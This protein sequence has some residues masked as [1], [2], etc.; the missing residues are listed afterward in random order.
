VTP[1]LRAAYAE[2]RRRYHTLAHIE[3]CLARLA[4]ISDLS[5]R[6]HALLTAALWWHDAV[7]DPTRGDNEALSAE[8]A[9]RDLPPLGYAPE[10]VVEIERLILLTKGHQVPADDPLG[11]LMVSI[12]LSILGADPEIYDAYAAA[13]REEYAHVPEDLYRA[14]RARVLTHFLEAGTLYPDPDFASRLEA[15]ARSNLR[16]EIAALT[17][18]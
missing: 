1:S 7:Y 16:R 2:P 18:A 6:D 4:A 13:I 5:E 9:A 11:A 12:D 10:D 3:D 15:P 8:M 17:A 14:G